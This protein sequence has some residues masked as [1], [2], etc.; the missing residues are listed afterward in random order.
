MKTGQPLLLIF[1]FVFSFLMPWEIVGYG[2]LIGPAAGQ[3]LSLQ[4]ATGFRFLGQI[5]QGEWDA[6]DVAVS[7]DQ[8]FVA[9]QTAGLRAIDISDLSTPVEIASDGPYAANGV[10]VA[11]GHV[12]VAGGWLHIYDISQLPNLDEVGTYKDGHPGKYA[13]DVVGNLAF[14][15]ASDGL[16]IVDVS[17]PTAPEL[18]GFLA[19]PQGGA[20]Y[21][22]DVDGQYAYVAEG[23]PFD[24]YEGLRIIDISIPSA[25]VLTGSSEDLDGTISE[26][27]SVLG[28]Y[29]YV[30]TWDGGLHVIDCSDPS[31]PTEIDSVNPA[32]TDREVAASG[33]LNVA[34]VAS[35]PI[36]AVDIS[37]PTAPSL[38]D[39]YDTPGRGRG[40][41][42]VGPLV[43]VIDEFDGMII[44]LFRDQ[45]LYLPT[46]IR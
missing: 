32:G 11:N 23:G 30:T 40:L 26:G 22:V 41:T 43:F 38:L 31:A 29:A 39:S 6:W 20:F 12:Y 35:D 21:D 7:G 1:L 14:L 28:Q 42:T 13:V 36:A 17:D 44:L 16:H 9:D 24:A 46:I 25:P 27:V 5:G 3:N 10:A 19:T 4:E 18:E 37:D 8:V 34:F 45:Q 33:T 15:A 2:P